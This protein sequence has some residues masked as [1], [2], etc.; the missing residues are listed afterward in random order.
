MLKAMLN[1]PFHW[2]PRTI[3]NTLVCP[4]LHVGY[5]IAVTYSEVQPI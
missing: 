4:D 1:T 5:N 3:S 2:R